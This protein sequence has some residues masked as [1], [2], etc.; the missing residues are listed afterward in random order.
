MTNPPILLLLLLAG[1][2]SGF[3]GRA[4]LAAPRR[5]PPRPIV[6]AAAL[7]P[8]QAAAAPVAAAAVASAVRG[9]ASTATAAA[10]AAAAG[11][12]TVPA[13]AA[14]AL[15]PAALG[16]WKTG[17]TV[18]YGYGGAV[19][20][21][22]ALVLAAASPGPGGGPARLHALALAFYGLRLCLFL[23]YREVALPVGVHQMRPR[24]AT[25]ADRLRR[26]PVIAGCASLYF[27]LAAPLRL[28]G[29]ASSGLVP[30]Q[31]AAVA[32]A[33]AVAL[34]GFAFAAAGDL[35]KTYVK[36]REGPDFLV[37]TGP[38]RRLRHP[39]YT[40]E[41]LGWTASY[42]AAVLAVAFRACGLR[43]GRGA[44]LRHA[45]PWLLASSLGWAGILF[46]LAGEAA[47]GLEKKQREKY[48]GSAKYQEWVATSWAGPI[49]PAPKAEDGPAPESPPESPRDFIKI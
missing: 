29:L 21:A 11:L 41:C 27:C 2:A 47:G 12:P 28:T 3:L 45:A 42:A 40:G 26:A 13:L 30:A 24:D 37:T 25:A 48:G 15:V 34:G 4:P 23:L 44:F 39:N 43:A 49:F 38:Y 33:A 10:A 35:F 16:L 1:S 20:A 46:V 8:P 36:A 31:A 9:G 6:A 19:L 22:A 18:S 32:A 14:A 7:P 5:P 17:Y